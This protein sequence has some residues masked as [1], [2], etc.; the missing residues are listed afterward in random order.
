[1]TYVHD[2]SNVHDIV[3]I[4][5]SVNADWQPQELERA[6]QRTLVDLLEEIVWL[7]CRSISSLGGGSRWDLQAIIG[8][9]RDVRL[10]IECKRALTPAQFEALA[11][12]RVEDRSESI[13]PILALPFVSTRVAEIAQKH[14]WGWY[15]LAG[16]CR[17]DVPGLLHIERTGRPPVYKAPQREATLAS[18][19]AAR[20]VRA[21]LAPEHA[22]RLWTQRALQAECFPPVSL[23]L[24]NKV[25][26]LLQDQS[27]LGA[28]PGVAVTDAAGLL[29]SWAS[30]YRFQNHG[31]RHYFTLLRGPKLA[32]ALARLGNHADGYAS[33]ASFS[34]ADLQAPHVRQPQ[35]WLYV[36]PE[37]E[38]LF[39]DLVEARPAESGENLVV[40]IPADEG[41]LYLPQRS[42]GRLAATNPVQTY[43]DL[44]HSGGRGEEAAAALLEHKLSPEWARDIPKP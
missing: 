6:F 13:L 30:T 29:R 14:H 40:L 37:A 43:V 4:G 20:V 5:L 44:F 32:D 2:S 1:L 27:M 34:A 15:D 25:V 17:I 9:R 22:G 3:N 31:R 28:E 33:Y 23:G 21:L 11:L 26:R 7:E 36:A 8:T 35:T 42:P 10:L 18:W 16:N 41:V 12:S 19:E 24:V 38:E 39:R